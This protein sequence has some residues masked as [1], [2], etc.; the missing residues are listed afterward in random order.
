MRPIVFFIMILCVLSRGLYAAPNPTQQDFINKIYISVLAVNRAVLAERLRL[1]NDDAMY[2]IGQPLSPQEIVWLTNLAERY[3]LDYFVLDD[4]ADWQ[5]LL[6]RVDSVPAS[7]AIAQAITESAWGTSRFA[8]EANNYFGAW[9]YSQGCGVVPLQ[10]PEGA[11]YEVKQFDSLD[12]SVHAYVANI[13]TNAAYKAFRQL[14]FS[15]RE[16]DGFPSGL[17][18]VKTLD[19]YAQIGG[20]YVVI[21][22][23]V[24]RDYGLAAYDGAS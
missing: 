18:L 8:V 21:L 7:V 20:A 13:N 22:E 10:R 15:I 5:V 11:S 19:H 9:C 16:N 2:R 3:K 17:E 12:A 14:R 24:M 4:S 6:M 23:K 1:E